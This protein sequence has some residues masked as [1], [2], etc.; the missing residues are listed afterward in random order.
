MDLPENWINWDR[1]PSI[2]GHQILGKMM[3]NHDKPSKLEGTYFQTKLWIPDG[4]LGDFSG[5]LLQKVS[6]KYPIDIGKFLA[7]KSVS[8]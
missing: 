6:S 3:R 7:M 2:P 1:N 4:I 8:V 5:S